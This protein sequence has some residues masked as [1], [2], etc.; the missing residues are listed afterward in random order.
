M[1]FGTDHV[2]ATREQLRTMY[3]TPSRLVVDK[4]RPVI[5]A[6]TREFI[7]RSPFV[8]IGTVG[9]DGTADVS[10][11]GG[12]S[13][14]V[15]VL[16]ERHIAIADLSGNNRLDTLENIVANGQ[17]G[18]LFVMPGQ[19]ETVRLNGNAYLTTDP[20]ILDGF[21]AELKPPK[22]AIIVE[23]VGTF[24]HCAKAMHRSKIWDNST[25]DAYA[26][27]PDGAEIIV[28]QNLVGDEYTAEAVRTDLDVGYTKDLEAER[29]DALG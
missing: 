28:C 13:G 22:V 15:Q 26:D 23:V 9:G 7:I 25:W 5:D 14:F 24:I 19:G 10:P 6:A 29:A 18:L 4:E 20:E 1:T 16:D 12:P 11:R 27:V 3:R 8:L 2:I 21:S 17:V